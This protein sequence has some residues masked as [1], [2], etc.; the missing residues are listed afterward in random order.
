MVKGLESYDVD[1]KSLY[2]ACLL[3]KKH[4]ENLMKEE[5]QQVTY[6]V[7]FILFFCGPI[8]ITTTHYGSKYFVIFIDELYKYTIFYLLNKNFKYLRFL[9]YTPIG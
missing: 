4:R 7:L 9:R 3:G 8:Q 2:R 6:L 5:H 1:I